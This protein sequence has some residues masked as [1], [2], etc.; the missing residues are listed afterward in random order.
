VDNKMVRKA[1][2]M[3]ATISSVD[4]A[5]LLARFT[6]AVNEGSACSNYRMN[7]IHERGG[8]GGFYGIHT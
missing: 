7:R 6:L 5:S 8:R 2:D 1:V 3:L 4:N